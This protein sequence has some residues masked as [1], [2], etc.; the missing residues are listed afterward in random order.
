MAAMEHLCLAVVDA[1]HLHP[2]PQPA[3]V[4][5]SASALA[6]PVLATWVSKRGARAP[7]PSLSVRLAQLGVWRR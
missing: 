3:L 2:A 7:P 4:N 1:A 5:N 6:V